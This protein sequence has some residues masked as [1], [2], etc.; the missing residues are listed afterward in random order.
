MTNLIEE[1]Q[2]LRDDN[3][4]FKQKFKQAKKE[5]QRLRREIEELKKN[6]DSF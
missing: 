1:N 3:E 4:F 2:K 5:N 6:L